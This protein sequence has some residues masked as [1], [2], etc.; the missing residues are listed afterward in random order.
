MDIKNM[1]C[2]KANPQKLKEQCLVAVG[3]MFAQL[4]L[5]HPQLEIAGQEILEKGKKL[6]LEFF[7]DIDTSSARS[8]A[9]A[10]KI[11]PEPGAPAPRMASGLNIAFGG[12]FGTDMVVTEQACEERGIFPATELAVLHQAYYGNTPKYVRV[13]GKVIACRPSEYPH[14][15]EIMQDTLAISELGVRGGLAACM[16]SRAKDPTSPDFWSFV[17]CANEIKALIEARKARGEYRF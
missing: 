5:S 8:I 16:R 2:V 6:P 9:K 4:R 10:I 3:S 11:A 13:N 7:Q 15:P 12:H 17:E 1:A 14:V